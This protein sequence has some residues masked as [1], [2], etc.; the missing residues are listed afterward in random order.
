VSYDVEFLLPAGEP[1]IHVKSASR[2]DCSDMGVN[3]ERVERLRVMFD[4]LVE[5]R[6]GSS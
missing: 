5:T 4:Q 3:R 2:L 6:D 1:Q